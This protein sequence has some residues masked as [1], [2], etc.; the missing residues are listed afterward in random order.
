MKKRWIAILLTALMLLSSMS[1]YAASFVDVGEAHVWAK[2]DIESYAERGIL[3]GDGLGH[4][5][6]DDNVTRAE[7][8]KMLCLVFGLDK[9]EEITYTDVDKDGWQYDYIAKTDKYTYT[10]SKE[11][12]APDAPATRAEIA[13]AIVN[14]AGIKAEG[15]ELPF[16]DAD[17]ILPALTAHVDTAYALGLLKGYPDNTFRPNAP[18]TRAEVVV[19]LSRA[20]VVKENIAEEEKPPV[21]DEPIEDVPT[22]EPEEEKPSE[23]VPPEEEKPGVR[24]EPMETLCYIESVNEV[25]HPTKDE[26]CLR[27]RFYVSSTEDLQTLYI[28][29]NVPVRDAHGDAMAIRAGDI[30]CINTNLYGTVKEVY[31]VLRM[32]TGAFLGRPVAS[33]VFKARLYTSA[34]NKWGYLEDNKKH[35]VYLGF[36]GAMDYDEDEAKIYIYP[37]DGQKNSDDVRVVVLP[38]SANVITYNTNTRAKAR[39]GRTTVEAVDFYGPATDNFGNITWESD[40][41]TKYYQ[42]VFVKTKDDVITDLV[43]ISNQ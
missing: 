14:A 43:V 31:I 3:A 12:Y 36:F 25:V 13:Y 33:N 32:G 30:I 34:S 29:K 40:A 18:V 5:F 20:E 10:E 7:F 1:G 6:P 9:A 27:I 24:I 2:A 23:Q 35:E 41:D 8:A 26:E 17:E 22:K 37:A 42:Y 28:D 15:V 4:F 38:G 11:N 39:Y 21:E 19:L 16:A